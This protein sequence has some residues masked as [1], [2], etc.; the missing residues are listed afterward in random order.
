MKDIFFKICWYIARFICLLFGHRYKF[1]K[2]SFAKGTCYYR[3]ERCKICGKGKSTLDITEGLKI[4]EFKKSVWDERR[5]VLFEKDFSRKNY[6]IR[7][8]IDNF[9]AE[10]L[11]I[12]LS[13][14]DVDKFKIDLH[15]H[16]AERGVNS[17]LV[18]FI[19]LDDTINEEELPE[20]FRGVLD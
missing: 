2:W 10:L 11:C 5:R 1:E 13:D 16:C 4:K 18:K 20:D 17:D 8:V 19:C 7:V 14:S 3:Y 12:K 15:N 6:S 9:S